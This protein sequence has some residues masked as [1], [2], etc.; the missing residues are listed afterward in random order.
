VRWK[1]ASTNKI[2]FA[3]REGARVAFIDGPEW[4]RHVEL[5]ASGASSI[6]YDAKRKIFAIRASCPPPRVIARALCLCSG[7]LPDIQESQGDNSKTL[8]L[9]F[10][11][12][13]PPVAGMVSEKLGQEVSSLP[14]KIA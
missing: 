3:L 6:R 4:G 9:A 10:K 8:W 5:S 12:V 13:P 11:D 7:C 1:E 14:F 2:I